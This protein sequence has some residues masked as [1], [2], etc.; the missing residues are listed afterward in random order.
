MFPYLYLLAIPVYKIISN[1][2]DYRRIK[3]IH[4]NYIEWLATGK[5]IDS[6]LESQA[7]FKK[8]LEKANVK[9]SYLPVCQ[10]VGLGRA[11]QYNASVKEQ[12]P[13]RIHDFVLQTNKM[14]YEAEGVYLGR[15]KEAFNPLYWIDL[16]VFLPK[17]LMNYFGCNS[18]SV[19]AKAFQAI[20]FVAV[21]VYSL[22]KD[23][24]PDAVRTLL[25]K[26]ISQLH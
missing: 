18:E 10:P 7:L 24:Y 8:L 1:F 2:Y 6:L 3:Q 15:I 21:G 26:L 9:E 14:I 22:I 19:L 17:H 5:N 12:F 13:S 11:V 23:F 20:Y 16:I 4:D 25:E